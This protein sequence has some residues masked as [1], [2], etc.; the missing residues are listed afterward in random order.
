MSDKQLKHTCGLYL[1]VPAR[2]NAAEDPRLLQILDTRQVSCLLIT[3][4]SD[5]VINPQNAYALSEAAKSRDITAMIKDE[6]QL[7]RTLKADGV[8]LS[9]HDD[10][11]DRYKEAREI[12]DSRVVVGAEAGR[13]RH[14]AMCLGE[15]GADYVAF[16][17]PPHVKDVKKA[18]SRQLELVRWWSK[19]FEVPCVAFNAADQERM[20]LLV[21]L[22]ADFIATD[23]PAGKSAQ[24]IDDW[25]DACI[26]TL[27]LE[28][29][30]E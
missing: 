22:G 9:W 17:I 10:I 25:F 3:P 5:E 16:A 11:M 13:S 12:V 1:C 19:I 30:D 18:Q 21:A 6:P 2:S 26:K 24:D 27:C 4:S 14:T 7:A 29:N 20:R 15:V 8:H 23:I 28:D